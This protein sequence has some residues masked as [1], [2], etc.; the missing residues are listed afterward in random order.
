M[1][2]CA[3]LHLVPRLTVLAALALHVLAALA[4]LY[5]M[6]GCSPEPGMQLESGVEV[7]KWMPL[8]F[9]YR[10]TYL[11]TQKHN[12]NVTRELSWYYR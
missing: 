7:E 6:A 5:S 9:A 4:H 8:P 1:S 3:K 10:S 11:Q 12:F 2:V